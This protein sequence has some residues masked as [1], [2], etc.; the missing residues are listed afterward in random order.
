MLPSIPFIQMDLPILPTHLQNIM[1][2][3][4]IEL[5]QE[6]RRKLESLLLEYQSSFSASSTDKGLTDLVEHKINTDHAHPIKQPPRKIPLAKMQEK[7][8]MK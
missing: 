1:K 7:L 2:K 4:P 6:Q 8:K 5:T 3:L